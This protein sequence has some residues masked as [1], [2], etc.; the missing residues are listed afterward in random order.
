MITK[1]PTLPLYLSRDGRV[2]AEA[3][4]WKANGYRFTRGA[5][6]QGDLKLAALMLE[7][8]KGKRNGRIARHLNDVRDDDRAVNLMWGDDA[9]NFADGLRNGRRIKPIRVSSAKNKA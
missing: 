6:S 7:T 2:F 3:T 9:Q 4:T 8:F 1:H 5:I